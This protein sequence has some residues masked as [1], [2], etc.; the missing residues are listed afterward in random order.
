MRKENKERIL[1]GIPAL[2]KCI[3]S[4]AINK[5]DNLTEYIQN[6]SFEDLS[7]QGG[8]NPAG[9]AGPQKDC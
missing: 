5:G 1:R 6:P 3:L 2:Q 8:N 7:A 4:G 9:V